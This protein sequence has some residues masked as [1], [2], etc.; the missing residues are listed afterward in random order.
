MLE[1]VYGKVPAG[2]R[3]TLAVTHP[4]AGRRRGGVRSSSGLRRRAQSSSLLDIIK[5]SSDLDVVDIGVDLHFLATVS[6]ELGLRLAGECVGLQPLVA[7]A[8]GL[9]LAIEVELNP[10]GT[11]GVDHE[12]D[13]VDGVGFQFLGP[14][15]LT[16]RRAG[17]LV[18]EIQFTA[19][20]FQRERDVST[21]GLVVIG[22]VFLAVAGQY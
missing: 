18:L 15:R 21:A 4:G 14:L 8:E 12:S 16:L 5:G 10:P 22:R 9:L 7:G 11:G 17:R 1:L 2:K 13:G 3:R 20:E 6:A 19:L